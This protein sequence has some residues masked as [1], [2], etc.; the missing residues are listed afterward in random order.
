MGVIEK[1][2]LLMPFVTRK[3]AD[4]ADPKTNNKESNYGS[5]LSS[6]A[7]PWVCLTFPNAGECAIHYMNCT[8]SILRCESA[9]VQL[10]GYSVADGWC[11][12]LHLMAQAVPGS[13]IVPGMKKVSPEWLG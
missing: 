6:A 11:T 1:E 2:V 10:H 12:H 9:H 3:A 13:R 7:V 5:D 8:L 4:T